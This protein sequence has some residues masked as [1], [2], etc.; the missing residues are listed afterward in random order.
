MDVSRS[1]PKSY[2]ATVCRCIGSI[3]MLLLAVA[4]NAAGVESLSAKDVLERY[5]RGVQAWQGRFSL[6]IQQLPTWDRAAANPGQRDAADVFLEVD[7]RK[8]GE[9]MHW[10]PTTWRRDPTGK[11]EQTNTLEDS[12]LIP[13]EG[14]NACLRNLDATWASCYLEDPMRQVR[15]DIGDQGGEA[16]FG[17][18]RDV[19]FASLQALLPA[20]KAQVTTEEIDGVPCHAVSC[21]TEKGTVTAWF[22]PD[23]ACALVKCVIEQDGAQ[24]QGLLFRDEKG[25]EHAMSKSREELTRVQFQE[26]N[27]HQIPAA[28]EIVRSCESQDGGSLVRK[29]ASK[30]TDVNLNPE[31]SPQEFTPNFPEGKLI[32]MM[33]PTGEGLYGYE[34]RQGKIVPRVDTAALAAVRSIISDGRTD[35]SPSA[36]AAATSEAPTLKATGSKEALS[37]VSAPN[38]ARS[39]CL[40]VAGL[41]LL[42][43]AFFAQSIS[44]RVKQDAREEND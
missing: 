8:D 34:W 24:V 39:L 40:A 12:F 3:A 38:R 33:R 18:F 10:K 41:A 43:L 44:R 23:K 5:D 7:I 29:V 22:A 30:V 32:M 26:I 1:A 14:E 19:D 27:G 28:Y 11:L 42:A 25:V 16:L 35:T 17:W 31:F 20:D 37:P 36:G 6:H 13:Y 2:R 4:N 21:K 9:R 15:T